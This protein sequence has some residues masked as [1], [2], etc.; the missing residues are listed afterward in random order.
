MYTSVFLIYSQHYASIT[1]IWFQSIFITSKR[2]P[3][4]INSPH[5]LFQEPLTTT[6]LLSIHMDFSILDFYI[7]GTIQYVAFCVWLI[8]RS[9]P[10]VTCISTPFLLYDWIIFRCVDIPLLFNHSLVDGHLGC[11][12]LLLIV[13]NDMVN[14]C[15]QVLVWICFQFLDVHLGVKFLYLMIALCLIFS[16]DA[17]VFS[18]AAVF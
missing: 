18:S 17:K 16:G 7:K 2:N 11:L 15:A 1:T 6:N 10:V 5:C 8:F 14:S 4:H 12:H 13:N 9:H 3:R